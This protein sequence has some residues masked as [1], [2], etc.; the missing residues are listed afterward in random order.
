[1]ARNRAQHLSLGGEEI[2]PRRRPRNA[3]EKDP[4]ETAA[5]LSKQIPSYTPDNTSRKVE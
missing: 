3:Y 2:G 4:G 5:A 1:M